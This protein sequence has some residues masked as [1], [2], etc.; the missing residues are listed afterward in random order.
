MVLIIFYTNVNQKLLKPLR[1]RVLYEGVKP[2]EKFPVHFEVFSEPP[3]SKGLRIFHPIVYTDTNGYA[4]TE[5]QLGSEEGEYEFSARIKVNST[6]NDIVYFKAFA[7]R[8]NWVF[9]L[10]SGLIGGLGLFLFGMDIMSE[11][12]K[13]TAGA[14]LRVI[15]ETLTN[16]RLMAVAVGTFITTI[17]QSSSATTVM[18][19]SFVQ[20][21]LITFSQTLGVILGAGIGTTITAQLIAFR[22]TDYSLIVIGVGFGI[23]FLSKSKKIKS[24][25]EFVLGFGMVFYG[26]YVMSNAMYP[27][28][29]YQPFVNLLLHLEN[30]FLGL[31]IDNV[32]D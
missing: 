14:K 3:K 19:V 28:R 26:M 30:P 11:G 22:I 8:S 31:L 20:A 29:T 13:K 15:L 27:L 18:L 10:I 6:Y 2:V 1:V 9:F 24:V 17:M 32:F 23:T 16:N 7:R 12:M 5:I 25:G 21:Q 4:Q